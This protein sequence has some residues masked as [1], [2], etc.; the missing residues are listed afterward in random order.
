MPRIPFDVSRPHG[1]PS[2]SSKPAGGLADDFFRRVDT[3]YRVKYGPDS[4]Q[5]AACKGGMHYEP[6]VAELL[7]EQ[8]LKEQP[9]ITVWKRHRVRALAREGGRLTA[10]TADDL[11][12]GLPRTFVGAVF[13][14]AS[15]TG[16]VMAAARVPYRIGRESR[17]E[18]G[19]YLAG[20]SA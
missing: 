13:I 14:D 3:Y 5:V 17:Q 2:M 9:R 7:F 20:I 10:L 8:M 11:A 4:K 15:Y 1:N 12:G 19:E 18:Y 16:D 6:H